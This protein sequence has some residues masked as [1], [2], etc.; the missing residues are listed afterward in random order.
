MRT[1]DIDSEILKLNLIAPNISRNPENHRI[2][3]DVAKLE[4]LADN[5]R[6]HGLKDPISMAKHP[7]ENRYTIIDGERRYR[8]LRMNMQSD[9]NEGIHSIEQ[10]YPFDAKVYYPMDEDTHKDLLFVQMDNGNEQRE[11]VSDIEY[12]I[13]YRKRLRP[14]RRN[15]KIYR[16]CLALVQLVEKKMGLVGLKE[17]TD[18]Q[19]RVKSNKIKHLSKII[20]NAGTTH[21]IEGKISYENGIDDDFLML[22]LIE[23]ARYLKINSIGAGEERTREA[24]AWDSFKILSDGHVAELSEQEFIKYE[25]ELAQRNTVKFVNNL[26]DT[27]CG[28]VNDGTYSLDDPASYQ[29]WKDFIN[30][31]ISVQIDTIDGFRN[32][33][34][35]SNKREYK[36]INCSF[37]VT[38]KGCKI[39][40][41]YKK[42][43][44]QYGGQAEMLVNQLINIIESGNDS[45]VDS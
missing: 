37:E 32:I 27:L 20:R 5:I 17:L 19:K 45:V 24:K 22:R 26:Y 40:L 2:I 29:D 38:K 12:G 44:D 21:Y 39:T 43:G 6:Q 34:S 4:E 28:V 33:S 8:A 9:I 23:V 25:S 7:T 13:G 30:G 42:L 15:G 16:D 10:E 14:Y 31:C 18:M 3:F 35:S 11:P 36:K 1:R 41:D